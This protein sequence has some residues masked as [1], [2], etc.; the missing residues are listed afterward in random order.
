MPGAAR[1]GRSRRGSKGPEK[2]L[3]KNLKIGSSFVEEW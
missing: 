3:S 1:R 2:G